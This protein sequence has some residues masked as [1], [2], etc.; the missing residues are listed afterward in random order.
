MT[1]CVLGDRCCQK[2][3]TIAVFLFRKIDRTVTIWVI[4][5]AK[6]CNCFIFLRKIVR[7]LTI[8]DRCC[9][10]VELSHDLYERC[11]KSVQLSILF[12]K[13]ARSF[14]ISAI[15]VAKMCNCCIFFNKIY[16]ALRSGRS[17]LSKCIINSFFTIKLTEASR[18]V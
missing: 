13:N 3:I 11:Y 16:E 17:M 1:P 7:S 14:K 2:C 10:N 12:I 4:D 8:C 6:I 15:D 18:S 9:K 5:V